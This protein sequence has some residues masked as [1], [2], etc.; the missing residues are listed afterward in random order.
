MKLKGVY[1]VLLLIL[2]YSNNLLGEKSEE[3]TLELIQ[4]SHHPLVTFAHAAFIYQKVEISYDFSLRD[5]WMVARYRYII[6]IYDDQ[7]LDY[8]DF[9]ISYY[10]DGN[11][12]EKVRGVKANTYNAENGKIVKTELKKEDIWDE[13][14]TENLKNRK[15]ALPKVKAGSV[16]EVEYVI[17]SPFIYSVPKWY[18]QGYIPC[19]YSEFEI[20]VPEYYS[21]SPISTGTHAVNVEST[22]RETQGFSETVYT[23]S[24]KDLPA[25]KEDKFILN[26][27]DYRTGIKY[28]MHSVKYPNAP[29]KYYSQNWNEIA[30]NLN[31]ADY[32]GKSLRKKY[33]ELEPVVAEAM[34]LELN[35]RIS[36]LY[37]Y[38]QENYTWNDEYGK[39]SYDG[40][41]KVFADKAGNV[42]ELNIILI[43]LLNQCQIPAYPLLTKSRNQGILNKAYPS[44]TE[45][46]YCLTYIPLANSYILLDA[47]SKWSP[48][49]ELPY[50]AIN[51]SGVIMYEQRGEVVD[52]PNP[53]HYKIQ[54]VSTYD[55]DPD[56]NKI[57]GKSQIKRSEYAATKY[58]IDLEN[59]NDNSDS[60]ANSNADTDDDLEEFNIENKYTVTE[61]LNIE[62]ISKSIILKYDEELYT[63]SKVIGDKI[64]IDATFDFGQKQNPFNMEDRDY[65]IF[66]QY[67]IENRTTVSLNLPEG[68]TLESVPENMNVVL[69]D[70][71]GSFSFE[72][73]NQNDKILIYYIFK[74]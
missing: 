34:K 36:Y 21:F 42:S 1:R 67:T 5:V 8:G 72:I 18:F 24:A 20:F 73:K 65:P 66:Y 40:L 16:L 17:S 61:L 32:F 39:G 49:G 27:N 44:L 30:Q 2:L 68:Y 50:R 12:K 45:L 3:I 63:C 9:S 29:L 55:I 43:N 56:N 33:K 58:R 59:K 19:N 22:Y 47:S 62:D 7:G 25:F 23:L 37:A 10:Q 15:F 69:P 71:K 31:D 51:I 41:K 6:K 35:Q 48:M 11:D 26:D 4:Q 53:N 13:Q 64:F 60:Q 46:N 52:L 28:E 57:I 70:Q 38:I 54:T 14:T 74:K